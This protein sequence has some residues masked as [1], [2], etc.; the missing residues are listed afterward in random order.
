MRTWVA[1]FSDLGR[2]WGIGL[3]ML[4]LGLLLPAWI[5]AAV[6]VVGP[7]GDYPS[8][9]DALDNAQTG[10]TVVVVPGT[11]VETIQ[12]RGR[13]VILRSM[14]PAN[15]N[16][17]ANTI[18]DADGAGSVVTFSGSETSAC[19][20]AGFTIMNGNTPSGGGG[21]NGRDTKATIFA[22]VIKANQASTNGAGIYQCD[23]LIKGNLILDNSGAGD[24]SKGG[25]LAGCDGLIQNNMICKNTALIEGGGVFLCDGTLENNTIVGN[26]GGVNGGGLSSCDPVRVMNNIIWGNTASADPQT[27]TTYS[28]DWMYNCEEGGPTGGQFGNINSDPRLVDVANNNFHLR[29]DSPCIDSGVSWVTNLTTDFDGNRR[30]IDGTAEPRGNG[31]EYD[32]GA[33]EFV[34]PC[35]GLVDPRDTTPLPPVNY[36]SIPV[37]LTLDDADVLDTFGFDVA[38][39]SSKMTFVSVEK[40][41]TLTAD[42]NTVAGS[43]LGSG[44]I[45]VGAFKGQGTPVSINGV[46]VTLRFQVTTTTGGEVDLTVQSPTDDL[47]QYC[48]GEGKLIFDAKG[49]LTGDGK[50]TPADAQQAFQYYLDGVSNQEH[51]E[52]DV[53][54]DT[55]ITPADAQEIFLHYLD[56]AREWP[57]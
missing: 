44:K 54:C 32:M 46:L 6:I 9:Q 26:D 2:G 29:A 40:T 49:D 39:D 16:V 19:V 36:V 7:T 17:V 50:V 27:H 41:G 31:T 38:F 56:P 20:L 33:D 18:I 35:V 14:N 15:R 25:G 57:C 52:A 30:P 5:Q 51:P 4:V 43:D 11:Y 21:I 1:P 47:T 24:Y 42:W 8:I 34:P 37:D 53:N 55:D 48:G 10:D 13:D 22:N 3:G 28:P 45:R 23:G 12:F